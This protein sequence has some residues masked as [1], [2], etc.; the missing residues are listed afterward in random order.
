[1]MFC[2]SR[3][4]PGQAYRCSSRTASGSMCRNAAFSRLAIWCRKCRQS[5]G[6]SSDPLP[7]RRQLDRHDVQPVEQ[8][9]PELAL[10]R[11][12]APGRGWSSRSTRTSTCWL[13]LLP[14]RSNV[15]S[16]ST[17]S[18]LACSAGA[19]SL[20]SSSSSVPPSASSKRPR[21]SLSAPVNAP[22]SWPNSSDSSRFS[23]QRRAVHREH[24]PL[25]PLGRGVDRPG[26]DFLA[27][28]ALAAD[29]HR[30]V[31]A[32][33]QLDL[34]ADLVPSPSPLPISGRGATLSRPCCAA[35]GSP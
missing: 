25:A 5:S 35:P 24:R 18:S 2:S 17:R 31:A 32:G 30:R 21:R 7:Q 14:T 23:R 27:R 16:C 20:I 34:L 15:L 1:M 8:V 33:D 22:F 6:M 26:D 12:P 3:T 11:P 9:L 10:R 28:A 4:L 29:Q 13:T 19:I